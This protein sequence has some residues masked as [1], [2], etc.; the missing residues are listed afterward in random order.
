ML[1][2]YKSLNIKTTGKLFNQNSYE[3]HEQSMRALARVKKIKED[4]IRIIQTRQ[5]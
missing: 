1:L 3:R 4:P 5:N 2:I